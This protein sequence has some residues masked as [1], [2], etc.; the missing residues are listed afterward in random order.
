MKGRDRIVNKTAGVKIIRLVKRRADLTLAQFKDYWLTRHALHERRAM[1]TTPL[2]K[3]V[4][5][6]AT[7]EVALGAT[8]P[9]FDGMVALYFKNAE[10]A[11]A[12]LSGPGTAAMR[13]DAKNFIDPRSS[14]Q[15]F[16][17]EY[18][19]SEKED[20][21]M[22][23]SGQLKT[24]RTISRRRDLTH[25]QFKD[26]WLNQHSRLERRVIE[27]TSMQRIIASFALPENPVVPD[28]DG[29]AELYFAKVEDIRAMF[30]G[31]VPA[32]MRKDEEN[33]VQMN[34]PA[35]RLV[36][37]EYVIGEKGEAA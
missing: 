6:I 2:Q 31:P 18:L 22:R 16:A 17:D 9:P 20:V 7:G 8:V 28:F 36:A 25:A 13:E 10:D 30:G 26:Y 15:I 21:A 14:P 33:F 35:V 12:T 1:A 32:M 34:A 11:R 29:L 24:I 3:V 37:E 4:A 19:V 5:S 23:R 27:T